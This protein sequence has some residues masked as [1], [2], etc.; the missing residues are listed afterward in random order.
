[1]TYPI[2]KITLA[3]SSTLEFSDEEVIEANLVEEVSPLSIEL[4]ISTVEFTVINLNPAFSMFSE[5][6]SQLLS[7]RL[8]MLVY[9]RVEEIDVLLGKFYLEDWENISTT[10]IRFK[11]NDIIGI[12]ESTTFDGGFWED[13]ITLEDLFLELFDPIDVAYTID[14]D[15]KARTVSGWIP[16]SN[17]RKALQQ[18]CFAA[19]V[20]ATSSRNTRLIISDA[21]LPDTA[22]SA[23]LDDTNRLQVQPMSLLN[24]VTSIELI[25]HNYTAGLVAEEIFNEYLDAGSHKIVF[26]KPLSG[27]VASGPGYTPAIL[28]TEDEGYYVGTEN[29]DYIEVGGGYVYGA[30]SLYLE[31]EEAGTV[32]ITGYPWIDS[33][34]S[35]TFNETGLTEFANKNDLQITDATL[36]D[37]N[38]AQ[39]VLDNVRDYYRLR[40][41]QN[42]TLIDPT[43]KIGDIVKTKTIFDDYFIAKILQMQFDLSGGYLA[44]V[45]LRGK[46]YVE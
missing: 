28:V 16:P 20:Q 15:V 25:S 9:E 39:D 17:Y 26:D 24:A 12:L 4:P 40:Y 7:E 32:T 46:L 38:R 35:Y 29:G 27:L 10:E 19:R 14:D 23:T 8:P 36:V 5:E 31:I 6:Y 3:D 33:K 41:E 45:F 2:I 1:M 34:K 18:I 30:N 22:Y 42:L 13:A 21:I 11:G 37:M 43:E 44:K